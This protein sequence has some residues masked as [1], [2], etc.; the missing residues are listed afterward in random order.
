MWRWVAV[1]V[2]VAVPASAAAPG[3]GGGAAN[4]GARVESERFIVVFRTAPPRVA[5]G[6]H[7]SL[8]ALVCARG[9]GPA[10]TGLRVDAHMPDHRH[11]MNYRATVTARGDG[12]WLADGL[13]FHM[14]GRWQL[15]FDVESGGRTE[16]LVRDLVLE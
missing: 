5:V 3:C 6:R 4:A 11:G 13:L 8:E 16:R 2:L 9:S 12:R 1:V 7:F 14:P 15:V 10:P